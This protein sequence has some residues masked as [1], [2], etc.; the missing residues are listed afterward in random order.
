MLNVGLD[1][2]R[3]RLDVCVLD[4]AGELLLETA[5]PPD[6]DGL[7]ML[8]Q[9]VGT[10]EPIRAAIESMNGARFVHDQLERS[11]WDVAIAD[12]HKTKGLAPLACKTDRIDAHVLATLCFR[13]LVPEV[14]LP[15]PAV[16]AERERA[17]Y[18]LHLVKHRSALKQRIAAILMT[19]GIRRSKSDLFGPGGRELLAGLDRLPEPW[20]GSVDASLVLIDHFD[21]EITQIERELRRAGI[22]HPYVGLLTTVPGIAWILGY[23]IAAEIG[24]VTRFA[25]PTKLVAYSGLCPRVYQSGERDRRGRLAKNGPRYLRWALI[26]A[27]QHAAPSAHYRVLYERTIRRLGKDRGSK[28]AR[29]IVARKL[30]GA[31]WHMLVRNEPFAPRGAKLRLAA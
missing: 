11:G 30:G 9:R 13:D 25:S 28:V 17:R 6:A 12:A 2:S 3:K 31:I 5:A 1:L 24:D 20:R 29:I 15:D 8:A 16:R 21:R 18:R 26:E 27:A 22:H 19:F 4:A 10:D 23:T 14:W 7:R